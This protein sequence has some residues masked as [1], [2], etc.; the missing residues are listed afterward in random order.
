MQV[1]AGQCGDAPPAAELLQGLPPGEVGHVLADR[2]YDSDAIRQQTKE[3]QA[4]ACIPAHPQRKVKKRYDPVRYRNR[5]VIERFFCELKRCRR[6]ATRYEKKPANFA[7]S[8]GWRHSLRWLECPYYL[9]LLLL[10]G[11]IDDP[12]AELRERYH[13]RCIRNHCRR[14]GRPRL[15]RRSGARNLADFQHYSIL[16]AARNRTLT[17]RLPSTGSGC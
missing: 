17:T 8:S 11:R 9:A 1:T 13:A 7:V 5:N 14:A 10:D 2:A 6:I 15:K 3:L 12:Q 4:K 16:D